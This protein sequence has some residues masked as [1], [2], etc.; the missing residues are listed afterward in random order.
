MLVP[1]MGK[2]VHAREEL[3]HGSKYRICLIVKN[4]SRKEHCFFF[5][6]FL[7]HSTQGEEISVSFLVFW[8]VACPGLE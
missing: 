5:F 8:L 6:F 7:A 2:T 1:A 4:Q 3:F